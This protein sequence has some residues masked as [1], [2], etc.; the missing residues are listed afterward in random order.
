MDL[1]DKLIDPTTNDTK[2]KVYRAAHFTDSAYHLLLQTNSNKVLIRKFSLA[3]GDT[4][5]SKDSF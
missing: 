5:I 1:L 3:S 4:T 2:N